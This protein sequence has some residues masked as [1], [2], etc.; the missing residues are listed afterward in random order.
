MRDLIIVGGGASGQE[1]YSWASP[2]FDAMGFNF[3]G[4]L[5]DALSVG[6][7]NL[8][9]YIPKPNDVFICSIGSSVDRVKCC[10]LLKEKGAE[11]IN[12]V[13]PSAI[14]MSPLI[15]KGIVLSPFV[16][17]SNDV[18]IEDYVLINVSATIGHN[19]VIGKGSTICGHVDLTGFVIIGENVLIGSHACVVPTKQVG[20]AAVVGAGSAV[21]RNVPPGATVIGVPAKRFI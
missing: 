5:D 18:L 6:F 12:L 16:F 8:K 19:V 4:F 14:V 20:E 11:F 17:V 10:E 9:D 15:G 21:M 3:K 7:S 1:M 13:H 2:H